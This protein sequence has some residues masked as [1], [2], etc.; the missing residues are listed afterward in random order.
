MKNYGQSY[1]NLMQYK[2]LS[3]VLFKH[4]KILWYVQQV[5]ALLEKRKLS[6][7]RKI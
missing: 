1:I 4:R 6:A 5:K 7:L 2:I 3:N